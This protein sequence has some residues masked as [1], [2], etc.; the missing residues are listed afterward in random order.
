VA[1]APTKAAIRSFGHNFDPDRDWDRAFIDHVHSVDVWHLER[2]LI[3]PTH[4]IAVMKSQAV[5][6]TVIHKHFSPEFCLRSN[7]RAFSWRMFQRESD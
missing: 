7:Q 4:M 2:G 6:R 5:E 1:S 3:K